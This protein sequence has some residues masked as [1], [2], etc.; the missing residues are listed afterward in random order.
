[1]IISILGMAGRDFRSKEVA[2][3]FYDCSILGRESGRFCNSVDVLLSSYNDVFY[4]IGTKVAITF[5]KSLLDFEGK[6]VHF[7]EVKDDSLDDI[8][9][10]ILELLQ[11][12]HDVILD[13]THGFR[14]QP[15]MA[16]FASTLSQ[17]LERKDLKIIYAKEKKHLESYEY[18]YLDE[19]IEITQISLLLT[20][21]IRT[22]NFIPVNEM[23]LLNNGVFEDF[24]KSLLSNDM[25]GVEKHYALLQKELKRLQDSEELK[26]ISSLITKVEDEL[27][28]LAIFAPLT[29]YQKYMLLSK[30]MVEKNYLVIALAYLFESLREYSSYRFEELCESISFK[31]SYERND[32]VMKSIGNYRKEN[33]ILKKYPNLYKQNKEMFKK[34]NK[35]YNKLRKRRNALAHINTK[36]NF[37][38]IKADL[39]KMIEKVEKLYNDRLLSKIKE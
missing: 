18:I 6:E 23:K 8:F 38:D 5:Q 24:S 39:E 16:I 19:Y 14:H 25:R 12:H 15:I 27:K 20:G 33:K 32:N 28:P 30:L 36:S 9:E 21:F 34:V 26:H 31:D 13:I 35:L 4:F 22:L 7:I 3:F 2:S 10:K 11:K 29:S 37:E 17:F 1:M